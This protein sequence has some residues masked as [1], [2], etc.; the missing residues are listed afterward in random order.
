M[1]DRGNSHIAASRCRL[2]RTGILLLVLVVI[3]S[4]VYGFRW[5]SPANQIATVATAAMIIPGTPPRVELPPPP[6]VGAGVSELAEWIRPRPSEERW[7]QIGW[8]S[9]I[10]EAQQ[11]AQQTRRLVFVWA[12]NEPMGR[13]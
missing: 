2:K 4:T 5:W 11:I 6:S 3:T 13:C 12:V 1:S 8:Q 9:S 7:L 10:R